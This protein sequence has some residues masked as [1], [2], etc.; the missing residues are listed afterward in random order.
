[1]GYYAG[2]A[3]KITKDRGN[4]TAKSQSGECLQIMATLC[5]S[6]GTVSHQTFL[7]A[8][9]R[10]C[11]TEC[12]PGGVPWEGQ[13]CP[14]CRLDERPALRC[15]SCLDSNMAARMTDFGIRQPAR[16]ISLP[17]TERERKCVEKWPTVLIDFTAGIDRPGNRPVSPAKESFEPGEECSRMWLGRALLAG[18][19]SISGSY[20]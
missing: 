12:T 10:H 11:C 9:E 13:A 6:S 15:C 4:I 18:G 8:R 14:L 1:M 3:E 20:G 19:G 5:G 7:Q 2:D 17:I 16:G